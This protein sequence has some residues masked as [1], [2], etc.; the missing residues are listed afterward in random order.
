[1]RD[2]GIDVARGVAIVAIVLGHV[3]RGDAA[4]GLVSGTD[5]VFDE[6]DTALYLFHLPVFAIAA[7]LFVGPSLERSGRREYLRRRLLLFGWLY[8]LWSLIQGVVKLATSALVNTPTTPGGIVAE[9]LAPQSQ[10][11]WFG[12][13]TTVTL[14]AA[15]VR[16]WRGG[17]PLAL[18]AAAAVLV[19]LA[20]WGDQGRFLFLQG[21]GLTAFFWWGTSTGLGGWALVKRH[22]VAL[23]LVGGAVA[24]VLVVV[25]DPMPPTTWSGA[26]DR[27]ALATGVVASVAATAAVLAGSALLRPGRVQRLLALLGQRSLEIF[28]AHIVATAGTRA[29]LIRLGVTE[30]LPQLVLGTIAGVAFPLALWWVSRRVGATW[31]FATPRRRRGP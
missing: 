29:V 7:G 27:T 4:A 1:V 10:L 23:L 9:L 31:L 26:P 22:A 6:L 11:W 5:E 3:L 15:A 24:G 21:L 17:W 13:L 18:S 16:P 28:L 8:L 19:S 14:A 12:F 20:F 2:A 25:T 30:L